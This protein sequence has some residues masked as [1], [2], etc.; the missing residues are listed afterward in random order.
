MQGAANAIMKVDAVAP[1]TLTE[2]WSN[3]AVFR[4]D[5]VFY[6]AALDGGTAGWCF[7]VRGGKVYGPFPSRRIAEHILTGLIEAF[8]RAGD[9]GGR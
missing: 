5:R 6:H 4:S 7:A 3:R 1:A 9:T 2:T 8:K